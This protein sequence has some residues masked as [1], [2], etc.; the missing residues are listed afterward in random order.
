MWTRSE[1]FAKGQMSSLTKRICV[2]IEK[3]MAVMH[4]VKGLNERC[5]VGSTKQTSDD[6]L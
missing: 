1:F 3:T 2:P 6:L 5:K 4:I